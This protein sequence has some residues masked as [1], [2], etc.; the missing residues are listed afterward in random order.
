MGTTNHHILESAIK[1]LNYVAEKERGVTFKE[2]YSELQIPKSTA[3]SLVQTFVNME[4]LYKDNDT[5]RFTIGLK[6]FEIG[7]SYLGVNS[8][9]LQA[10]EILEAIS[11]KCNETTHFAVLDG[12]DIVY[13]YKFDSRQPIRIFS[14]IGKRM[15]AHATAVGKALLAAH[16]D[17]E[18]RNIYKG[19]ELEKLTDNTITSLDILIQ[20]LQ[21]IR[22]SGVAFEKEESTPSVQCIGVA[23]LSR[24]KKPAAGISIAI[25]TYRAPKKLDKFITLLFEAKKQ[26]ENM[27]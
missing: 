8:L 3:Y 4:Y 26:M 19:K 22:K 20:Q 16:S 10:K 24:Q 2:I 11:I 1:I 25:P 27:L 14:N 7:N 15:P 21:E 18:I 6:C 12:T 17:E 13:I 23:I 5:G 9:F